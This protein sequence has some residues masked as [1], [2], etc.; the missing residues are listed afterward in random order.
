M[1]LDPLSGSMAFKIIDVNKS[2]LTNGVSAFLL[3][4]AEEL[5]PAGCSSP[6]LPQGMALAPGLAI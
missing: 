3:R 4:F 2:T 6:F 1:L 5:T